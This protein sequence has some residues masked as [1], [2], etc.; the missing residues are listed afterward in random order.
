MLWGS[1]RYRLLTAFILDEYYLNISED[2]VLLIGYE[3]QVQAFGVIARGLTRL[4][5]GPD[6]GNLPE[7]NYDFENG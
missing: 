1:N 7:K 3:F 2:I 6:Q 5:L 4:G